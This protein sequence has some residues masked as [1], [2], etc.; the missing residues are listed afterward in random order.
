MDC[1][2]LQLEPGVAISQYDVKD[3]MKLS[4]VLNQLRRLRQMPVFVALTIPALAMASTY[5]E[6]LEGFPYPYAIHHYEFESQGQKLSMA[7]M[8]IVPDKQAAKATVV[9]LHGKNFCAATWEASIA[10]LVEHGYR[11]IAPDQI[12]FCASSKPRHYQFS[13]QQLSSNTLAL[14][15]Q[16]HAQHVIALGHS[17]GGMLAIRMALMAPHTVDQLVL[18]DPIGLEDWKALGVPYRTVDQW[19]QRELDL[20]ADKIRQY[21]KKTYYVGHWKPEFDKWVDMLAGL[22][23]G[24]AHELVAWD[25]ALIYDMIYTQPVVYE[26]PHLSMHTTL[27]IGD[28]DTTA[29]GSDIAP[30]EVQAKIGHYDK[31]G[32]ETVKAIPDASLIVFH[33]MGH[34]PQ[35]EDPKAFNQALLDALR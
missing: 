24:P 23:A 16:L 28:A 12:G 1:E 11:V 18:V 30:P 2:L 13:F 7:Y 35:I 32:P 25:S 29:I 9:M 8:D 10:A 15:D 22:N 21:E 34:A 31:L 17:T 6:H 3:Y 26:L 5:G 4:I 14:L 20:S 27:M 33:G 19:Y